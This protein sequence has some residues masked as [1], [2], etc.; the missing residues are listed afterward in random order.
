[1]SSEKEILIVQKATAYD[2]K[3]IFQKNPDKTYT[4]QELND[5][6]DAYVAGSMTNNK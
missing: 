1:M 3:C 4:V 5:I 6:I 2:L